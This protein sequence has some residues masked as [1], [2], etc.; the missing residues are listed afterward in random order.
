MAST[1]G[2]KQGEWSCTCIIGKYEESLPSQLEPPA[3]AL[4]TTTTTIK[5]TKTTT[6]KP[7]K[8]T[9]KSNGHRLIVER[10]MLALVV[11]MLIGLC[12]HYFIQ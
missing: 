10:P 12:G 5:T 7:S 9:K 6:K 2:T 1:C 4:T 11:P 8:T 3:N